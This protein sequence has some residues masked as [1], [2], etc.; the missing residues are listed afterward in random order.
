MDNKILLLV[1]NSAG[2]IG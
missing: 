2:V 1:S